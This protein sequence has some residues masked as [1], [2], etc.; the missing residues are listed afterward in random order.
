MCPPSGQ[1]KSAL[2]GLPLYKWRQN[3]SQ[4]LLVCTNLHVSS[5]P[6]TLDEYSASG[7]AGWSSECESE[8][9][10]GLTC[11][12]GSEGCCLL[13]PGLHLHTPL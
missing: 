3:T 13:Y 10:L 5:L 12:Q 1:S 7:V 8:A 11:I 4:T 2:L 6:D 9:V